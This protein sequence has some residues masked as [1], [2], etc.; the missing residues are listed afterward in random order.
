M[1][2]TH[3]DLW[4]TFFGIILFFTVGGRNGINLWYKLNVVYFIHPEWWVGWG[5]RESHEG[6][7]NLSLIFASTLLLIWYVCAGIPFRLVGAYG[8]SNLIGDERV[9]LARIGG[10]RV[11]SGCHSWNS[12]KISIALVLATKEAFWMLVSGGA[13]NNNAHH[14]PV[15][16]VLCCCKH[17]LG[18]TWLIVY[19]SL[20]SYFSCCVSIKKFC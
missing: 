17:F 18:F 16:L 8:S 9:S 15:M 19:L 7:T 10:N 12:S 14:S 20:S 6:W 5:K 11:L 1:L 2:S 4:F 3:F 13:R